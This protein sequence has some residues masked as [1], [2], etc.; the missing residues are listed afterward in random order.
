MN[1]VMPDLYPASA[2]IFILLMACVLLV[3][4]VAA[5]K[6]R[7]WLAYL[8]AQLTLAGCFGITLAT[9]DGQ[10]VTTFSNMFVDDLF[11]DFLKLMLYPAVAVML[12]YSREYLAARNLDKGEF[13]VLVLFA[14]LGMMV[15]ISACHF[16][17]LYLGLEML[18]L[19]LYALV[20]IDRDSARATE[21]AMKYFVL[22]AMASGLLLYGMS[23]VYGA[24]GSLELFEIGQRIATGSGNKT[25]LVFGLVFIVAGLAFKLGVVPFHMWIPDVYEGAP[26][27]VTLF[28]GSAP[29]LAAF[30][31]A[32]RLLVTGLAELAQ[33]WQVMLMI[34]AALSIALG[35]LAA[36][37]QTNLKRMLAYST[38]SHMG[39]ML[40]GLLS[41]IVGG[42]PRFAL[43][44]YSSAM[45]YAIAYVLMS[46]G[47]FGMILLL[48]R[49]GFEAENIA[50]FKGLNKRSPWFAAI[51]M[52]LMFSLAGIPFFV[53]FFAKFAVLQAVVAA[54]LTW[55]AVYAVL[56]SLVGAFYYLRVV[57]VMYFDA[58]TDTAPLQAPRDMRVLL[59]INGLAVA[60][61]GLL[62]EGVLKY[63][64]YATYTFLV[65]S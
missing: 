34:L 59:S 47:S 28:I 15:M 54:N 17:T 64:I 27:A 40:L 2:E 25:V 8:L 55:L 31:I 19:S 29:K 1:F 32:M 6:G 37:A 16:L 65:G 35:N 3:V 50:D 7:R 57:K 21:A 58:P 43:N 26:T 20:A 22:G 39:F 33:H 49:A 52:I 62:P 51:M 53:G 5:G 56:F 36:I 12:V 30:A 60:L 11:A 45:F 18:A 46:L 4:D 23:M 38:I 14:T 48:S 41:G 24:V 13:Y 63:S 44:A 10:G 61:V 42:D 9:L